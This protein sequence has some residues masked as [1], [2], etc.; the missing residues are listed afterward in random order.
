RGWRGHR[1]RRD[2]L[3]GRD[4]RA[5]LLHRRGFAGEQGRAAQHAGLRRS[6]AAS[7][8]ARISLARQPARAAPPANRSLGRA[9]RR[10]LE[11]MHLPS[12]CALCVLGGETLADDLFDE[13]KTTT[14]FAFD[15]VSIPHSQNLRLEMRAP[16]RH[17]ANPVVPRGAAGTPDA[18]GVQFYG[19]VL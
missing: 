1:R 8:T 19:S 18:M 2:D 17:P 11:T 5:K 3:P 7:T 16:T 4:D 6:G 15:N 14:L 12:L 10:L 13:T 9:S